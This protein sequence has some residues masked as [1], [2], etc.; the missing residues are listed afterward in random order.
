MGFAY[1]DFVVRWACDGLFRGYARV[2]VLG[3]RFA[4]LLSGLMFDAAL[5]QVV[6]QHETR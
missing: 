3:W 1:M 6:R 2:G 4:V 5:W